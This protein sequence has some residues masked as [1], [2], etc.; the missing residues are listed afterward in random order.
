[1]FKNTLL[2]IAT[3]LISFSSF[4]VNINTASAEELAAALKGIGESKAGAIVVYREKHG[5][6]E[7]LNDLTKVK[8]VGAGTVD[9]NRE[10]IELK[11]K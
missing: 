3:L 8:G 4:A 11:T 5:P 1:M 7:T 9:K 10:N 6:F 2:F